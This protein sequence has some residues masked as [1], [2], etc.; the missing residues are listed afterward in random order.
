M[1]FRCP[2][3]FIV[4][5]L[6]KYQPSYC[7]EIFLLLGRGEHLVQPCFITVLPPCPLAPL[8]LGKRGYVS[9]HSQSASPKLPW[10]RG[11]FVLKSSQSEHNPDPTSRGHFS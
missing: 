5:P 2:T 1:L 9:L 11:M 6:E 8:P 7:C 3:I 4:L 10:E